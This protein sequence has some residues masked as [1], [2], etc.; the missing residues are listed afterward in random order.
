MNDTQIELTEKNFGFVYPLPAARCRKCTKRY[1]EHKYIRDNR[2]FDSNICPA[3]IAKGNESD[4]NNLPDSYNE[5][6]TDQTLGIFKGEV[7]C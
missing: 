1:D 6:L 4:F 3:A 7:R 5:T 2:G